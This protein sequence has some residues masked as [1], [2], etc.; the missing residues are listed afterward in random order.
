MTL[1]FKITNWLSTVDVRPDK[2]LK[3]YNTLDQENTHGHDKICVRK[4]EYVG[5][6]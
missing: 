6:Q 4:S 1:S 5:C 3:V 2:I